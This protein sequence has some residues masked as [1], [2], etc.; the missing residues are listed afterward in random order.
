MVRLIRLRRRR[1]SMKERS[2]RKREM[3]VD[4]NYKL[5]NNWSLV[6]MIGQ[7]YTWLVSIIHDWSVL[8]PSWQICNKQPQKYYQTRDR[9]VHK[10]HLCKKMYWTNVIGRVVFGMYFRPD[11]SQWIS[12]KMPISGV[13]LRISFIG[14]P[15]SSSTNLWDSPESRVKSLDRSPKTQ[16]GLW[17]EQVLQNPAFSCTG[18]CFTEVIITIFVDFG[19]SPHYLGL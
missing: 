9:V 4:R 3:I 19:I 5:W 7:Y 12:T 2:R 11:C 18:S 15:V 17:R 13:V 8:Y 10:N 16:A 6:Y 1:I 14:S